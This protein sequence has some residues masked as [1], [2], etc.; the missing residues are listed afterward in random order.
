M[1]FGK[2]ELNEWVRQQIRVKWKRISD[3]EDI[4]LEETAHNFMRDKETYELKNMGNKSSNLFLI[5]ESQNEEIDNEKEV[6]WR[7]NH[8]K[9]ST[10]EHKSEGQEE[11]YTSVKFK[12]THAVIA[13]LQDSPSEPHLLVFITHV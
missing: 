9:T 13:S 7:D 10:N 6:L 1:V 4:P 12:E 3:L 5:V 2:K 11:E 8:C